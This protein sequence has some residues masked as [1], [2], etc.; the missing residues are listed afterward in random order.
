MMPSAK[1]LSG[2]FAGRME[3]IARFVI[4]GKSSEEASMKKSPSRQ[5]YECKLC[6]KRFDDLILLDYQVFL[7][8]NAQ[9]S[10]LIGF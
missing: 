5:R 3:D 9:P 2:N 4:P 7:P 10:D 1:I 6:G 8:V